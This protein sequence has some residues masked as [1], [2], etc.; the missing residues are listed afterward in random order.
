MRPKTSVYDKKYY[1]QACTVIGYYE[2]TGQIF[3]H[4]VQ[5]KDGS[6]AFR[7]CAEARN[8]GEDAIF[9]A[10]IE[11]QYMHEGEGLYLPGSAAVDAQ[12]VLDQPEFGEG[13]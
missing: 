2:S 12:T 10:C 5:A 7:A 13:T 4:H 8:M 9:V 6:L 1:M 3:C 11:G